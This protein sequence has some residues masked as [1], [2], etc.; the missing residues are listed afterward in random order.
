MCVYV[1]EYDEG[2]NISCCERRKEKR[3]RSRT[4]GF[5]GRLGAK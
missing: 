2:I 3:M 1:Q 4:S 5:L